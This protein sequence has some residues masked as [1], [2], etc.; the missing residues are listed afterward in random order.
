MKKNV[1][2]GILSFKGKWREYQERVL[3][4]SD[5]YLE[6]GKIHIV[7]APGAGK[8]TLDRASLPG[9]VAARGDPAAVAGEDPEFVSSGR[10]G[11]Y[12]F[13]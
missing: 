9:P 11:E 8:T 12:A 6:D 1:Y 3:K 5:S 2:D 13:F 7:A 4:E 10:D